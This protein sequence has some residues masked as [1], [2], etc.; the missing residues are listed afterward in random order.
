MLSRLRIV[1]I[2]RKIIVVMMLAR[3]GVVLEFGVRVVVQVMLWSWGWDCR[4][5]FSNV[6]VVGVCWVI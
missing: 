6:S 5:G 3:E 2:A 4:V 1:T